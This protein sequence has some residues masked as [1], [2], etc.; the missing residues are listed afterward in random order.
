DSTAA[1][2]PLSVGGCAGGSKRDSFYSGSRTSSP[3]NRPAWTHPVLEI[4]GSYGEGG[5][6]LLRT[7]VAPAAA[8]NTAI[9]VHSIRAKRKPP[10]LAPQ[11]LA[12][13]RAAR[14]LCG[15][16]LDGAVPRAQEIS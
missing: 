8:T 4:D 11:H 5:G 13:V 14:E 7:A 2:P 6:Q 3:S 15:G 16:R 12:A 1:R 10:G 9:R